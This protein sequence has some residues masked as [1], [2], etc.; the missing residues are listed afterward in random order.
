MIESNINTRVWHKYHQNIL[1]HWRKSSETLGGPSVEERRHR[2]GSSGGQQHVPKLCISYNIYWFIE[3]FT[4]KSLL[5]VCDSQKSYHLHAC[6]S[7]EWLKQLQMCLETSG[8]M[9]I[10]NKTKW[11]LS[12]RIT[13]SLLINI[14]VWPCGFFSLKHLCFQVLICRNYMGDMDMNE[15]DHF[16]PILMKKEEDAEMTPLVSHGPSH[17]LWIKHNNLYC[18]HL[19]VCWRPSWLL[20]CLFFH[21]CRSSAISLS[22]ASSTFHSQSH[23]S[24]ASQ[25]PCH[26]NLNHSMLKRS[27]WH[28]CD[29]SED[30]AHYSFSIILQF[31]RWLMSLTSFQLLLFSANAVSLLPQ[32]FWL[33][34]V[35][36][37]FQHTCRCYFLT[38][39]LSVVA[40]TKKNANA[41]LVYS[42]LYKIIQVGVRFSRLRAAS[43]QCCSHITSFVFVSGPVGV[44]GVLQGVGRGEH[45]RQL[46][47]SVRADGRGD[48][49][50]FPS[51]HWQQDLTR[52]RNINIRSTLLFPQQ[53]N[54]QHR[55]TWKN[56]AKA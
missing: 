32:L 51:D 39:L 22:S 52:V 34:T 26:H 36:G 49:L 46:C 21:V 53:G 38:R 25:I 10:F 45:P 42:F 56:A 54:S 37:L 11:S 31:H 18:I 28:Q 15:I 41:A 19:S 7:T 20:V 1:T 14:K 33:G 13:S 44:Q 9:I 12:D 16:M 3:H 8:I 35:C 47:D 50:W 6:Y 27:T 40:M 23:I 5:K 48:G 30:L 4:Q 24:A 29:G 55:L 2:T 17:F 43:W